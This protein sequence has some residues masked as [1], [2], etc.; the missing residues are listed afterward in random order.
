MKE[1]APEIRGDVY[2]V[3]NCE[4]CSAELKFAPGTNHLLCP[5]CNT[6][7]EILKDVEEIKEID[8]LSFINEQIQDEEQYTI[9]EI[10]CNTCGAETSL[11]DHIS[12]LECPYCNSSLIL[13]QGTNSKLLKPKGIL[14]FK[15]A[16]EE[17][18][19][20]FKKWLKGKWFL[21]GKLKQTQRLDDK[22]KGIYVPYWTYDSKTFTKYS[23]RR[24]DNYTTTRTVPTIV[25]G[26][27]VMRQQ[28]VVETRWSPARGNVNVLFDDT[29][30]IAST[31]LPTKYLDLLEPF[32]LMN[33]VPFDE[34]YLSGFRTECY[35]IGVEDGFERV[36][37]KMGQIINGHIRADIGGDLQEI[38]SSDTKFNDITFKHILLPIW[39]SAYNYNG[40]VYRF[41]INGRTGEVHGDR[42]WDKWKIFITVLLVIFFVLLAVFIMGAVEEATR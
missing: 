2:E 36:K 3:I 9:K 6:Q 21:P 34:R 19:Q 30:I 14:P 33:L 4:N 38:H 10:K 17:A 1:L 39:I 7:N 35:Q 12:S 41:L 8:Y 18:K 23:G 20:K 22:V 40:K 27:T 25:N 31:T 5:Y 13:D 15:I 37:K 16:E 32:D 24:G 28:T 42:P 29:L 11:P 26:K